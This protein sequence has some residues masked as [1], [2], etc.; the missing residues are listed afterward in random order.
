MR[1]TPRPSPDRYH[2][3]A[4]EHHVDEVLQQVEAMAAKEAAGDVVTQDATGRSITVPRPMITALSS[5]R[6]VER[7][8]ALLP[9]CVHPPSNPAS[10]CMSPV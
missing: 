3:S 5:M 8:E 9:L 7:L 10:A 6:T 1:L 2:G 4:C